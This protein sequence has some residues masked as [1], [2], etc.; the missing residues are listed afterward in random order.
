MFEEELRVPSATS[1]IDKTTA[2]MTLKS[3]KYEYSLRLDLPLN[4]AYYVSASM[5]QRTLLLPFSGFSLFF[6]QRY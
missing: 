4:T 6:V 2:T 5:Y 3:T 1:M